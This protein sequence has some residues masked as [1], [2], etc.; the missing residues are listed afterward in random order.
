VDYYIRM[1]LLAAWVLFALAALVW[2]RRKHG[3]KKYSY[4]ERAQII[5]D[6][7][8]DRLDVGMIYWSKSEKK[9]I[10]RVV[11]PEELDGYS[12]RGF[13]HTLGGI[14]IFK[15]TRIRLI[16]PIPTG[17]PKRAPSRMKLVSVPTVLAI[18]LGGVALALLALALVRGK[19]PQPL[20]SIVPLPIEPPGITSTPP[21]DVLKL[22]DSRRESPPVP[23]ANTNLTMKAPLPV[24][25]DP[26]D[27]LN[28][29]PVPVKPSE[30]WYLV[31]ENHPQYKTGQLANMLQAVLRYRP[32][33]AVGLEQDVTTLGRAV[34]WSGPKDRAERFRQLLDGYDILAKIERAGGEAGQTNANV[35]ATNA[36]S[37]KT[38]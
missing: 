20:T 28:A 16:E 30:A 24:E 35:T 33:R 2:W 26:D 3:S 25:A 34:V 4:T 6:A 22:A 7:I 31:V 12:M 13:D 9:F 5:L 27:F 29:P 8:H 14:R 1:G 18:S 38:P 10:R 23:A 19:G 37:A 32:E 21:A 36:I 15:V 17:S 11:T